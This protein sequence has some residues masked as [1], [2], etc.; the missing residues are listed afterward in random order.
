MKLKQYCRYLVDFES[1]WTQACSILMG[2]GFFSCILYYFAIASL[3]D[4]G[5]IELIFALLMGIAVCGGFVVC[6]T[7]LRLNAPGLYAL[8]GAVQCL[9]I[10]I[11]SFTT[12]NAVRIVLSVLW[13]VLAAVIL[14]GTAG[15]YLPGRLLAG[16][17]FFVSVVVRILFFD[18]GVL[19]ILSWVRELSILFILAGIGSFAMGLHPGKRIRE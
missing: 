3:R 8:M 19:D 14:L 18:L 15:G 4:V 17:M 7:C 9:C 12:G 6:V 16:L 2:L 11:L 13:Y 1:K 5:A 10:L